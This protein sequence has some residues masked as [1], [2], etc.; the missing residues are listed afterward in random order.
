MLSIVS[1]TSLLIFYFFNLKFSRQCCWS[2]DAETNANVMAPADR[3]RPSSQAG[4]E[5]RLVMKQARNG[6]GALLLTCLALTQSFPMVIWNW[7]GVGWCQFS[8]KVRKD[9][10][11]SRNF[12]LVNLWKKIGP[13][14]QNSAHFSEQNQNAAWP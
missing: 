6:S 5:I 8:L 14:T 10:V 2:G 11:F 3:P 13:H 9:G 7:V 4:N 1:H 12:S